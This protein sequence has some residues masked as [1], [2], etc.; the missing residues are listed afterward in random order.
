MQ[1]IVKYWLKRS[2]R[3]WIIILLWTQI[4]PISRIFLK[5][6]LHSTNLCISEKCFIWHTANIK[7]SVNLYALRYSIHRDSFYWIDD[8][9][10]LNSAYAVNVMIIYCF[11]K[12]SFNAIAYVKQVY[13]LLG[14]QMFF[15]HYFQVSL[16][17]ITF[18]VLSETLRFL[19]LISLL[20]LIFYSHFL[21][22]IL[23]IH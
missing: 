4:K 2:K 21:L 10:I 14:I 23:I 12:T 13:K 9:G 16:R 3:L 19:L 8:V 18:K 1:I 17:S 5:T 7:R 15:F 11:S 20:F 6:L 22:F